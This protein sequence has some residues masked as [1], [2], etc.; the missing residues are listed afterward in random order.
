[1]RKYGT[2]GREEL[3]YNYIREKC[4]NRT[5]FQY[6]KCLQISFRNRIKITRLHNSIINF[7]KTPKNSFR[8]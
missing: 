6:F 7:Q 1:M 5:L 3:N 2:P 4:I 8:Y